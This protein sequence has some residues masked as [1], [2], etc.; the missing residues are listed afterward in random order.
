MVKRTGRLGS[1]GRAVP[2]NLDSRLRG[3][4]DA[5]VA[6][7]PRPPDTLS[8]D[9]PFPD[10][11]QAPGSGDAGSGPTNPLPFPCREPPRKRY[12]DHAPGLLEI[13]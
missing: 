2:E 9:A 5:G 7:R 11:R 13:D 6:G 1:Q 3:N 8:R 10:S 4:D 12:V